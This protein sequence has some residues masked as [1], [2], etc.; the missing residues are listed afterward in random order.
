MKKEVAAPVKVDLPRKDEAEAVKETPAVTIPVEIAEEQ[1]KF[2]AP[3][4]VAPKKMEVEKP[5]L[6][7]TQQPEVAPVEKQVEAQSSPRAV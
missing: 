1:P 3:K 2:A 5:V 7:A 4:L 6:I